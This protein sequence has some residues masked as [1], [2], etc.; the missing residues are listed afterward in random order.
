[1]RSTARIDSSRIAIVLGGGWALGG[2]FHAGVL[3]ALADTWGVEA[4]DVAIVVGTSSG[5]VAA[6]HVGAGLAARDLFERE[7]GG[8]LSAEGDRV[9]ASARAIG[10][11]Q[12]V[13]MRL[14]TGLP[15]APGLMVRRARH[16]ETIA[17]GVALAGLL[18]RGTQPTGRLEAYMD[19]LLPGGWPA[20]PALRLC[21][22]DLG[23]GARVVLDAASA[24]SPGSAVAASCSV[25]GVHRP[26]KIGDDELIDGAVHSVDNV[27]A[28]GEDEVD[29]V[30][31]SSPL[32]TEKLLVRPGEPHGVLRNAIRAS[33]R[34][35]ER[36]AGHHP[37]LV[38][39]RPR[40]AD[41][42]AMGN[43]LNTRDRRRRERVA[44][45]AYDTASAI[46]RHR[47]LT[48]ARSGRDLQ[49]AQVR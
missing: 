6:G 23:S 26:V 34:V 11:S 41:V 4:R 25:P 16:P 43:D 17:T 14:S 2:S 21:A 29:V 49:P 28:V 8:S 18:P 35:E 10:T 40:L 37:D 13:S 9:L 22:V 1:M 7:I 3:L 33:S 12:R 24:T 42:R 32:S 15:A 30:I 39:I 27:D 45:E 20:R 48:A 31:V 44:A 46:F 5:A 38:A 47:S 36:R 19:A